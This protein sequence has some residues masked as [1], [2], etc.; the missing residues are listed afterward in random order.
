MLCCH[1]IVLHQCHIA[2]NHH[3]E[4]P[5]ALRKLMEVL[6]VGQEGGV[7]SETEKKTALA[8]LARLVREGNAATIVEHFK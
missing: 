3:P 4:D 6:G 8:Q 7:T 1:T 2:E 5:E